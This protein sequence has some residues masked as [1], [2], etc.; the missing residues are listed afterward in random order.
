MELA[1]G[2]STVGTRSWMIGFFFVAPIL[3]GRCGEPFAPQGEEVLPTC[4]AAGEPPKVGVRK[5]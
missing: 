2:M 3:F 4:I 1:Q 5:K